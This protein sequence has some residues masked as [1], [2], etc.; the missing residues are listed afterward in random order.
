MVR[1]REARRTAIV[2]IAVLLVVVVGVVVLMNRPNWE[3]KTI[4]SV[5]GSTDGRT[6]EVT[7]PHA[8]CGG[9]PSVRTEESSD[10]VVVRADYDE[11]GSCDSVRLETTVDVDLDELLGE[12]TI[13][14]EHGSLSLK[15]TIDGSASD[16]CESG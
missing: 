7:V 8:A 15:C 16:R 14:V 2:S 3:N 11:S 5:A 13:R 12:R 6:L 4:L 10:V 1:D 9:R